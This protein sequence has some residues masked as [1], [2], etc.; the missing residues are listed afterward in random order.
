MEIKFTDSTPF[1]TRNSNLPS[2]RESLYST[3]DVN[4]PPEILEIELT[5]FRDIDPELI[6]LNLTGHLLGNVR[7]L[8]RHKSHT[9]WLSR[10]DEVR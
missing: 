5:E 3:F 7:D 6:I 9:S 4:K 8:M 1:I 10:P 2:S